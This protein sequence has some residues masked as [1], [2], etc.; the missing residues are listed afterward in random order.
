MKLFIPN[1]LD[2]SNIPIKHLDRTAYFINTI[3]QQPIYNKHLS[4]ADFVPLHSQYLQRTIGR[5]HLEKV[6][7]FVIGNRLVE[8]DNHF[9]INE[10]SKGYRLSKQYREQPIKVYEISGEYETHIRK[11]WSETKIKRYSQVHDKLYKCFEHLTIEYNQ[12]MHF[13]ENEFPKIYHEATKKEL[14][15]KQKYAMM[16]IEKIASKE[17]Y[18]LPDE[19]A[20][21]LHTNLT[22][23][24]S[25]L[26][27]FIK[28]KNNFLIEVDISNCQPYLFSYLL[29]TYT[30]KFPSYVRHKREFELFYQLTA[31][32]KFYDYLMQEMNFTGNRKEFKINFFAKIFFSKKQIGYVYDETKQFRKLFPTISKVVDHYKTPCYKNLS[33]QLQKLEADLMINGVC[34]K[35][36]EAKPE[37]NI[38]TIHDSVMTTPENI[39]FVKATI[40]KVF[41]NKIG[42]EPK[43]K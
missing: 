26:R 33:I 2:T 24:F 7:E 4:P 28:A 29:I 40:K 21:R 12:A 20:N 31:T 27:K 37:I 6:K 35:L 1:N 17:F 14:E 13:V 15:L 3:I 38:Y 25:T 41:K 10:K 19:V 11:V 16:Q 34:K 22:N 39:E 42:K 9:K 36:I 18:F 32:G 23:L 30:N 43:I 5:H 8:T